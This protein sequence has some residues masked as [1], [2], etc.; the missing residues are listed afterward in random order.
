MKSRIPLELFM[1]IKGRINFTRKKK[2]KVN[3]AQK[4]SGLGLTIRMKIGKIIK[5]D[6]IARFVKGLDMKL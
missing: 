5:I 6:C 2:L 4:E 1:P 3:L